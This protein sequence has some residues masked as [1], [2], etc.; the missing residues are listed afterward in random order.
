MPI[1]ARWILGGAVLAGAIGVAL[2]A[3]DG[4]GPGKNPP[5]VPMA[6]A[7][8]PKESGFSFAVYGDSRPMMYLPYKSDQIDKIHALLADMF[9]LAMPEKVS[10]EVVKTKVK[11]AFDPT[12]HELIRIQ[13][14]FESK[15]E[16]AYVTLE[17]GW[18]PTH[19]WK[20]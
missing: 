5:E 16:V 9:S 11:L 2:V 6:N 12:T 13:M 18:L 19:R 7:A 20:T 8:Q 4:A 14:P 10:Q 1:T 3:F 15:S 17:H